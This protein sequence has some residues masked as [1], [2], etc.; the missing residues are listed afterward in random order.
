MRSR[1][2]ESIWAAQMLSLIHICKAALQAASLNVFINTKTLR[3]RAKAEELNAQC[4][5]M[6]RAYGQKADGIYEDVYKRQ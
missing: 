4:F 5:A 3:D 2:G 1:R 6:L